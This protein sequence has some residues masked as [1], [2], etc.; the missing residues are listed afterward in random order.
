MEIYI[1]KV[2]G[3]RLVVSIIEASLCKVRKDF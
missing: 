2:A 3:L 1:K